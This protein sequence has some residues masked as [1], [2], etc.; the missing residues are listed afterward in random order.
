MTVEW[1]GDV[2]AALVSLR[3]FVFEYVYDFWEDAISLIMK[4]SDRAPHLEYLAKIH[5]AES[6]YWKRV[7]GEW[8]ICDE[9][10]FPSF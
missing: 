2:I 8:V 3:V 5:N 4:A 6:Q 7:G 9:E 1:I 10:E